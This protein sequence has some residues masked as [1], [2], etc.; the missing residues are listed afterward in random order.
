MFGIVLLAAAAEAMTCLRREGVGGLTF[1]L[2]L[3]WGLAAVDR[4]W[5]E[6]A[7]ACLYTLHVLHGYL[8]M[9]VAMTYQAELLAALL[10]GL[11]LGHL[12]FNAKY[13][14]SDGCVRV[15]CKT[16]KCAVGS[17]NRAYF[18]TITAT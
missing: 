8:L 11:L 4:P 13:P 9:L 3:P 14:V 16:L 6:V 5:G 1:K 2:G 10:A 15:R 7:A 12:N 17:I 18:V